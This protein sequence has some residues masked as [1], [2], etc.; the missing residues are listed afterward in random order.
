MNDENFNV[1]IIGYSSCK[2]LSACVVIP[3]FYICSF[4]HLIFSSGK[5][6]T[7]IFLH[8]TKR[9]W[10]IYS[11]RNIITKTEGG[12]HIKWGT[13]LRLPREHYVCMILSRV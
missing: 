10:S 6:Y 3:C 5:F 11:E 9:Q 7:A 13:V 4:K 2:Q 12:L 1:D 8:N